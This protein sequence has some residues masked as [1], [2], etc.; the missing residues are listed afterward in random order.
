MSNASVGRARSLTRLII[1]LAVLVA[2]AAVPL[3]PAAQ[4]EVGGA[5]TTA[6]KQAAAALSAGGAFGCARLGDGS[7][8][9][10]GRNAEGQL[11]Q[12]DTQARGDAPGELGDALPA[13]ALGTGRTVRSVSAG[14]ASACAVLDDGSL[15]CWGFNG[16]GQLGLGDTINRG[17]APGEMGDAL[18]AVPLGSGRGAT[19]VVRGLRHVCA[20]LDNGSVKCWGHNGYGQLGLGDTASR[21]D[22]PNELGDA[23]APVDLGPGRSATA[24]VAGNYFS[25][26]LLDDATVKCWGDNTYGA[27]GQGDVSLRGD[28]PGEMGAAL[29]AID[30]GTGRTA[31]ALTTGGYHACAI[32]DDGSVKCWGFA[33]MLGLGGGPDRGDGPGEMGDALPTVALGTGRTALAISAG[34]AHTC[35]VLDDKS[36]KCWGDNSEGELGLGDAVSRG[37]APGGMGDAL[38]AVQL[39]TGRTTLAVDAGNFHSCALLDDLTVKCWGDGQ[40]G[41]LG[42]GDNTR[43]GDGPGEMGDALAPVPFGAGLQVE[44]VVG[45]AFEALPT[46]ARLADTRIGGSTVDGVLAGTGRVAAGT[47]LEVPVAGRAGI[48]T[49]ASSVVLNV[50]AVDPSGPGYL[51]AFPCGE[52]VPNAS[53]LNYVAGDVVPN[54]VIA[55]VG[56]GGRVCVFTFADT[57]VLVDVSAY[58]PSP[59]ALTPLTSPARVLDTRPNSSTIDGALAGIGVLAAGSV[60]EVPVAGRAGVPAD[61]SSVVVNLTAVEPAAGGYLTMFP[62]GETVPNASN[63]NYVAGDVVANSVIARVGAGGRVCIYTFADTHLLVDVSGYVAS[64]ESASP[65]PAPARLL[66]TRPGGSTIDGQ[67]AGNGHVAAGATLELAVAGRAGV[68]FDASIAVLNVTAVEPTGPGFLTVFPCGTPLPNASNLNYTAGQVVANSVVTPV[69][70]GGRVCIYTFA[71]SDLIVDVS[72]YVAA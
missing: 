57:D 64:P 5:S 46:P 39:G 36:V 14:N 44:P 16:D 58:V 17:D 28:A 59:D 42:V 71:E 53:N 20:L 45:P 56:A 8:K 13:I 19:A 4:A 51:T 27:L 6:A 30:L 11:G 40:F 69:G 63:L 70:A 10:W 72:A 23:L 37:D 50:T 65:L 67:F 41:Q 3:A 38:P 35:A 22:Q 33:P 29:P 31:R 18:P 62:C 47:V 48:P 43:R 54:S 12:G 52:A 21:G 24:V 55:R 1:A 7:L 61:A 2:T 32:L 34:Q 15:K 60:L 49:D 68:P 66:D 26:A 25:C 9:C